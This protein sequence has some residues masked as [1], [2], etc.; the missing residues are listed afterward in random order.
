MTATQPPAEKDKRLENAQEFVTAILALKEKDR[1]KFATLKRNAGNTIAEARDS[2]WFYRFLSRYAH[3]YD[4]EIYFL[5]ATLIPLNK[6]TA[7]GDMGQSLRQLATKPR[8]N[9]DSV[10]RRFAILLDADFNYIDGKS[11]GGEL[12]FRLRQ[13]VKLAGSHEV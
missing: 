10:E 11:A 7:T 6:K 1:G 13:L 4:D 5:V 8:V 9:G 12:A 2:T 3:G